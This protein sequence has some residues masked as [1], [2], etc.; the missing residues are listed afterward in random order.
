MHFLSLMTVISVRFDVYKVGPVEYL[1]E[2]DERFISSITFLRNSCADIRISSL[3]L[4]YQSSPFRWTLG[5]AS[6]ELLRSFDAVEYLE[7]INMT[8]IG[9]AVGGDA[10]SYKNMKEIMLKF[11]A[12]HADFL[13]S[14]VVIR[15]NENLLEKIV[16]TWRN[17]IDF[18]AFVDRPKIILTITADDMCQF[19]ESWRSCATPWRCR[20]VSFNSL[21]MIDEFRDRARHYGLFDKAVITE[22]PFSR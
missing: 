19:I 1:Q 17:G 2:N 13:A 21:I 12:T 18:N 14:L 4:S 3:C 11:D 22:F 8:D 20:N 7:V 10:M 15:C 5:P 6:T 16:T 9:F